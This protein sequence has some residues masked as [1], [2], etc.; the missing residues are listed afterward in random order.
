MTRLPGLDDQD[1]LLA[2]DCYR[3]R[4]PGQNRKERTARTGQLEQDSY[5]KAA[6]VKQDS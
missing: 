6:T 5:N 3:K 2:Q 1:R 4:Q